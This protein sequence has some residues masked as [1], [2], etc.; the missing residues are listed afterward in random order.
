MLCQLLEAYQYDPSKYFAENAAW[1]DAPV[2]VT[3]VPL[4]LVFV[5]GN[6]IGVPHVLRYG[7]FLPA[8]ANDFVQW[9]Q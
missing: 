3:V 6:D 5:Y 9:E 1:G 2:V 8:L 7:S 4:A